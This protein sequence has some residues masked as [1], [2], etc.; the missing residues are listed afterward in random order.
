[1]RATGVE[2]TIRKVKPKEAAAL[3]ENANGIE[4]AV[5]RA[6][7]ARKLAVQIGV[8]RQAVEQ[9]RMRGWA[10][11]ERAKQIHDLYKSIPLKVLVDQAVVQA[12]GLV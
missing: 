8:T 5:H 11:L 4:R 7:G 12:L 9:W 6:G 2:K 10:P 1:M 3:S